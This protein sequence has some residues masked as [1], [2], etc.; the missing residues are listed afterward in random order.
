MEISNLG[1]KFIL[2][3]LSHHLEFPKIKLLGLKLVFGMK[4]KMKTHLKMKFG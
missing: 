3:L 4:S 1:D 2:I